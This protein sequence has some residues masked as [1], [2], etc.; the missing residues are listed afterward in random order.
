MVKMNAFATYLII[1]FHILAQVSSNVK[2]SI[3][4]CYDFVGYEKK[5]C[6][7]STG[8]ECNIFIDSENCNSCENVQCNAT[9]VYSSN[10]AWDCT[11]IPGGTMG[12]YCNEGDYI[13]PILNT[14]NCTAGQNTTFDTTLIPEIPTVAPSTSEV[15]SASESPSTSN[16]PSSSP[17]FSMAPST[18]TFPIEL[19]EPSAPVDL[20]DATTTTT[21]AP[22][23]LPPTE[24]PLSPP[25]SA[26][27]Y[28]K[29]G[30]VLIFISFGAA[31]AVVL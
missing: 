3:T 30:S 12:S 4:L 10:Y 8:D 26:A 15:P 2:E 1:C 25:S 29:M 7:V 31:L 18:S 6:F 22:L 13:I 17:T 19:A 23:S 14:A 24:E 16:V 20:K 9:D 5:I 27:V 21:S 28:Y 11:N